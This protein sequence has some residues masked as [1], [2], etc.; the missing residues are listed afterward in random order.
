MI[1]AISKPYIVEDF[2]QSFE[3]QLELFFSKDFEI[4]NRT[5]DLDENL[6]QVFTSP[7]LANFM[8]SLLK[9]YIHPKCSLLDPCIGPNTFF[10]AL[11]E[12]LANCNLKGIE[13]DKN[14]I[15]EDTKEF[16]ND[17]KRSLIQ[18][19][20][21]D[22]LDTEKFDLIIQNPPYVRQELLADG[23]NSKKNIK[24]ESSCSLSTIPSQSNL[25]IYFLLKSIMHLNENG[26]MV[27]V[28]YDSWLY[29]SFGTFLKESFLKL[30]HLDS[31]Y[32]FKKS[33]FD[34]VEV[35]A[36]VIKFLK[37]KNNKK[38]TSYYSLNDLSDLNSYSELKDK[39]H[40]LT[41]K[42]L[43][44]HSFNN[45]SL[46]DFKSTL[47][48]TLNSIVSQPIQRGTSAI[49]N[50]QFIFYEKKFPE[51][52]PI[53]KDVSKI[54]TYNVAEEN[55]FILALNDSISD[56][57]KEYLD[58]VKI[59]IQDSPTN[60]YK[61]VKRDIQTNKYWYKIKLKSCGN[62]IF[63]YYLRNNIDF[64]YNPNKYLSSD[65][66]YSVNIEHSELAHL[67]L[68]NSSFTRLNI[69]NSSRNQGNG[70]RKIQLYEF[71]EVK[72]LDVN[73]L[74]SATIKELERLSKSLILA[75][76]YDNEQKEIIEQID[77]VLLFEYNEYNDSSLTIGDIKNE[78]KEYI[79]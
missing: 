55:A 15:N 41:P 16:Y 70:L 77:S 9:D 79:K 33:A 59:K 1:S 32:H 30:G 4:K 34:N 52:K 22:L 61:A 26:V 66:F 23:A 74:S 44:T 47:F 18:G 19:S 48:K 13:I 3:E 7:I 5:P 51:L 24:N 49:V 38:S 53:I 6:G 72:T 57:T 67:A 20:F 42:E 37:T 62:F 68:L 75:N 76:R 27:A 17:S 58:F 40:N 2:T 78:I 11:P 43:L 71:K 10:K 31:I 56:S 46:I 39:P 25:Y 69:L 64:I 36:T 73:K 60:K 28:I 14:L 63:N 35:G 45:A 50:N 65:N 21:F 12:D 29:S 54:K 8:I